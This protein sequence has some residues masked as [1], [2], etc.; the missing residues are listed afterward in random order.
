MQSQII[1]VK[2]CPICGDGLCRIRV[3]LHDQVV[4]GLVLC[5]ECESMWK[6]PGMQER[7]ARDANDCDPRCPDCSESLWGEN[8]HWANVGEVCLLG[9]FDRVH[10][11][12][13]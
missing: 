4:T 5:D 3:C 10:I 7:L 9:W 13:D 2:S 6:D 12:R 1:Y 8:A 11:V